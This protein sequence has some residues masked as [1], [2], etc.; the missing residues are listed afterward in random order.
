MAGATTSGWIRAAGPSHAAAG[1]S[2]TRPAA[3][4]DRKRGNAAGC[5]CSGGGGAS[6]TQR[7]A[8]YARVSTA[9][10]EQEQTVASQVAALEQA[11]DALGV[12]VAGE[13]RHIDEGDSGSRHPPGGRR[14]GEDAPA[15]G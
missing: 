3:G 9:R 14:W 13:R 15:A 6:M 12:K 7:G 2:G 8:L 5:A 1:R 11:A 10:Q 4:T